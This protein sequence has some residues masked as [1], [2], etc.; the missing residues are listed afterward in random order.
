MDEKI[1]IDNGAE[2]MNHAEKANLTIEKIVAKI[3]AIASDKGYLTEAIESLRLITDGNSGDS[4][5][6]GDIAGQAKAHA[7]GQAVAAREETNQ[8]LIEFY[9]K[10]YND[11][12]NAKMPRKDTAGFRIFDLVENA[13]DKGWDAD[14]IS[15]I[16][17]FFGKH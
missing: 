12:L 4:G 8:R 5:A 16:L 14:G 15:T 13:I 3:D 6:H 9:T 7:L 2:E 17:D 1:I 10:V 11:M